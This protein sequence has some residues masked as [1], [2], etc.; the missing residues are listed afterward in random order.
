MDPKC[1]LL[2]IHTDVD[3]PRYQLL[4]SNLGLVVAKRD[5]ARYWGRP[6]LPTLK[7]WQ[8]G[9]D[10]YMGAEKT[11]YKA[12]GCPRK[13]RKVWQP[14]LSYYNLEVEEEEIVS[15]EST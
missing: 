1:V 4:L 12:R 2:G 13:F 7:E 10:M 11:V 14:W 8:T 9:M 15:L 6:E 5:I 3:I